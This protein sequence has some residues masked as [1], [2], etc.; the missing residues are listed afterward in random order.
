MFTTSSIIG[1]DILNRFSDSFRI[2]SFVSNSVGH[3]GRSRGHGGRG[4]HGRDGCSQCSYCK[5]LGYTQDKCYSLHGFPEKTAIVTQSQ[6]MM[7]TD[8]KI[9]IRNDNQ[10]LFSI[11][12][13]KEYLQLKAAQ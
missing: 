1:K 13:Y 11:N 8:K 4:G 7:S 2:F 3:G 9:E 10:Y 12:E 6:A 5:R